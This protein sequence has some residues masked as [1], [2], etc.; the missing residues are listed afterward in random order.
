MAAISAWLMRG[1][2]KP[3]KVYI[4]TKERISRLISGGIFLNILLFTVMVN[5]T[6]MSKRWNKSPKD[7]LKTNMSEQII[8]TISGRR[9]ILP[10]DLVKV[11]NGDRGGTWFYEE[12]A[13]FFAQWLSMDFYF[14]CNDG[15]KE[16]IN[17]GV[18]AIN[19]ENLMTPVTQVFQIKSFLCEKNLLI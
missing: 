11:I 13:L 19:P 14:W 6:E 15:I 17:H 8:D 18:T 16:I 7:W 12:L 9:K 4:I 10:S 2:F 3:V 1:E 5:A